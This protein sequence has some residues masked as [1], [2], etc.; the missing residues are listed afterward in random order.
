MYCFTFHEVRISK[1]RV[2]TFNNLQNGHWLSDVDLFMISL[3][4]SAF[5]FD[6]C[7]TILTYRSNIL[8]ILFANSRI[9]LYVK[10]SGNNVLELSRWY[11]ALIIQH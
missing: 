3:R 2:R 5:S 4:D 10:Y 7:A 9:S 1:L 6:I 11:T 8:M